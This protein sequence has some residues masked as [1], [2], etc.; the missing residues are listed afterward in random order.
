MAKWS[1]PDGGSLLGQDIVWETRVR[2][3]TPPYYWFALWT[4]GNKWNNGAE[5]DLVESF[6]YDNGGGYTNYDGRYWHSNTVAGSDTVNYSNWGNGMA[7]CGITAYDATQYHIWTWLYRKDN[8]Y[9]MY[10]DGVPVQSGVN[11]P[12]TDGTT[13]GGSPIDINFLFDAGWGHTQ[14]QSVDHTLPASA[15][16]GTLYEFNYSRVYLSGGGTETAFNGP[17]TVPGVVQAEDYDTGGNS[18]GYNQTVNGGQTGYR[19]DNNGNIHAGAGPGGN[20]YALGWSDTGDW[21]RYTVSV[22]TAGHFT[23]AFQVASGGAGGTFHL[24]DEAGSN[25]TG[26]LAAPN[27]GGWGNWQTVTSSAFALSAGTHTL[28]L[29]ED[30]NGPNPWVCDFDWFSFTAS[31]APGAPITGTEFDDGAGPWGGNSANAASMAL[32]GSVNTFYDC[33]NPTG[34][35]GLDAG[36]ATPVAQIVFAPRAGFELRMVGGVFEGGNSSATTGYVTLATVTGTPTDGLTN[37]LTVTNAGPYRWLRYHDNQGGNC[38]VAEIQ[39]LS[40]LTGVP[41]MPSGLSAV[42]GN[43][44]V[45]LYWTTVPGASSYHLLRSLS[46]EYIGTQAVA[47]NVTATHYYDTKATNGVTYY[48]WVTAVNSSGQSVPSHPFSAQPVAPPPAPTG[49]S[50]AAGSVGS[51]TIIL[52]W[53]ASA[54][55]TRYNILRATSSGGSYTQIG[56]SATASFSNTR[57]TFGT[58]YFYKVTAAN[59]GGTSSAAGPVSA[60]AP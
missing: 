17:H 47:V 36:M 16:G 54:G 19:S 48:Y 18:A 40:P 10:V 34:Y 12:W 22:Q 45:S 1:L 35:V 59:A 24:E 41:T 53:A 26:S 29:V 52:R 30:A 5:H 15:F 21:Y 58:T 20:G 2:Y 6:G 44:K 57:L 33:A 9:A 42:P 27:T 8:S 55:A 43:G 56:S 51:K 4:S 37:T 7:S 13:A 28:R 31:V 50:A 25:L 60:V 49:L 11:Y 46:S 23:A 14:V 39:F 38:N 32:D 3:V